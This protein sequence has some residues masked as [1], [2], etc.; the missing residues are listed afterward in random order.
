MKAAFRVKWIDDGDVSKGFK[1]IYLSEDD[2]ENS[3]R[4]G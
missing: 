2:Y 4:Q 3:I 1:Y